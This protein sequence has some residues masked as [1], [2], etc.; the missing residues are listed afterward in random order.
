[1]PSA[2]PSEDVLRIACERPIA[3]GALRAAASSR[4]PGTPQ[5]SAA[6]ALM[7]ALAASS[8][9]LPLPGGGPGAKPGLPTCSEEALL[10]RMPRGGGSAWPQSSPSLGSCMALSPALVKFS[11]SRC[12]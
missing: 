2:P 3:P 1:M 10:V 12:P 7:E 9:V 5:C 11:A 4:A 8:D 6:I